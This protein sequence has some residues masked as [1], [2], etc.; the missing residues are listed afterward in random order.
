MIKE[1]FFSKGSKVESIVIPETFSITHVTVSSI[2]NNKES[3]IVRI[4]S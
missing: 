2:Q 3:N 4:D 1:F